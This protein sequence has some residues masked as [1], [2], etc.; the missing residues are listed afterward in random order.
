MSPDIDID[1]DDQLENN[2]AETD[3]AQQRRREFLSKAAAVTG[4]AFVATS[5]VGSAAAVEPDEAE[6]SVSFSDQSTGGDAVLVDS[7]SLEI[8]GYVT[9]H[10]SRLL[11]GVAAPSIVGVTPYLPA[12]EY[13]NI[14]VPLQRLEGNPIEPD[15][16]EPT[17]HQLIAVPHY[18]ASDPENE[19]F[20]FHGSPDD[21]DANLADLAF[22]VGPKE[23]TG[24]PNAGVNDL[25]DVTFLPRVSRDDIT[26]AK[27]DRDFSQVSADTTAE[28]E[29]LYDRQPF[30]G[31]LTV[32]TVRTR[33]EIATDTYDAAF[34]DLDDEQ[35]RVAE[36]I[37]DGQ[38]ESY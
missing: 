31:G 17:T 23:T 28:I 18:E 11:D 2:A 26:Q 15:G 30:V 21:E 14:V 32:D 16:S 33:D 13:E 35:R 37:Y 29:E 38:F 5:G 24:L 36:M 3:G 19:E 34:E 20:N 25:A 22:T 27:Y 8:P 6:A 9:I 7:T 1:A 12:G 10:E 4:T